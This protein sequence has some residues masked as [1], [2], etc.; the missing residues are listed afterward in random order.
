MTKATDE[1]IQ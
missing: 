1:L